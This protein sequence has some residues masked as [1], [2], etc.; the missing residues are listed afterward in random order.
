MQFKYTVLVSQVTLK[1]LPAGQSTNAE[2]YD[3][4]E[5]STK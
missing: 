5:I 1:S 3:G 2:E 4:V